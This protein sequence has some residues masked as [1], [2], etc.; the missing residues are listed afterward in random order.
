MEKRRVHDS[1]LFGEAARAPQVLQGAV[2]PF[3][4]AFEHGISVCSRVESDRRAGTGPA[5][6]KREDYSVK[7][8]PS[9]KWPICRSGTRLLHSATISCSS[10][11]LAW[12]SRMR[13]L[14]R[15]FTRSSANSRGQ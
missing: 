3:G 6:F 9:A 5:R 15:S 2:E 12:V 8:S 11:G 14:W 4:Q 13:G 10:P 7:T 1:V